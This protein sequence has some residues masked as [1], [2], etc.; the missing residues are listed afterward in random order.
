MAI[1]ELQPINQGLQRAMLND[2]LQKAENHVY[3]YC[4]N[5]EKWY[6]VFVL[7]LLWDEK[8]LQKST[9]SGVSKNSPHISSNGKLS[10]GYSLYRS[11]VSVAIGNGRT[12]VTGDLFL[13]NLEK[14][15]TTTEILFIST[16]A[17]YNRSSLLA[18]SFSFW[19]DAD[20]ITTLK[21]QS[22]R[23]FD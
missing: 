3:A 1:V 18:N 14:T 11:H 12:S 21:T 6:R 20:D 13:V 2:R 10:V 17:K 7:L 16:A 4:C 5:M 8:K 15:T 23:S 19:T 9:S 22:Y